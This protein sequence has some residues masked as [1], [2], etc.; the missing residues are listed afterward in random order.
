MID[1]TLQSAFVVIV[2]WLIQLGAKYL[3]F[4]LDATTI[5]SIAAVIVTYIY[6]KLVPPT[7][8]GLMKK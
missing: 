8:H 6:S 2:A 4:P 3:S 1:A 7:V 5:N